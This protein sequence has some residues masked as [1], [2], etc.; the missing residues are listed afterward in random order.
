[1]GTF[2]SRNLRM[3]PV[4]ERA[5]GNFSEEHCYIVLYVSMQGSLSERWLGPAGECDDADHAPPREEACWQPRNQRQERAATSEA[6]SSFLP[7]F[8]TS[9]RGR[10]LLCPSKTLGAPWICVHPIPGS[11]ASPS[12]LPPPPHLGPT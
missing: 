2:L 12:P 4:P 1:M 8:W 3:V 6:S 10:R 5:Y 11:S 9:C 7:P